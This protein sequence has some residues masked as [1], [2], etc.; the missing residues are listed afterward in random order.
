MMS[1]WDTAPD[2]NHDLISKTCS[3][4]PKLSNCAYLERFMV[5]DGFKKTD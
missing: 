1:L 5:S 2:G 3:H 4:L